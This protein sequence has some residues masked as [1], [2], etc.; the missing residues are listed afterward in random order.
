MSNKIGNGVGIIWMDGTFN[1]LEYGI[2]VM[3]HWDPISYS[4]KL[5]LLHFYFFPLPYCV[6]HL[7]FY[8]FL[9][10]FIHL[11]FFKNP[12]AFICGFQL[13]FFILLFISI[14]K[15]KNIWEIKL[16]NEL[17]IRVKGHYFPM[18]WWSFHQGERNIWKN[19]DKWYFYFLFSSLHFF[20]FF[21][22]VG[23]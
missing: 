2:E 15:F 22:D 10:C 12:S 14:I 23:F 7:S 9:F 17:S 4:L 21:W 19:E 13:F 20:L 6:L 16:W 1:P 18:L 11:L 5:V 3:N 8:F